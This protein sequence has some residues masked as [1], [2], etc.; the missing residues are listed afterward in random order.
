M[1]AL[2]LE[3]VEPL[4]RIIAR[5]WADAVTGVQIDS[6]RIREGDLFVAVGGGSDFVEHALARGASAALVPEDA[7]AALAELAAAVRS[8]SKARI[9]GITGSTGKTSTKDILF[10][11]CA[12]HAAHDRERG[13]LQQRARSPVDAL[14][15]RA[16]DRDLHQRDGDARTRADR[17][18]GRDGPARHRRD[19]EH[20]PCAPRA[21]RDGR[22]RRTREGRADRRPACRRHRRRPATSRCSSR[23]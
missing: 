14:P 6:R 18:A 4:G 21:R 22:E 7:H 5:P 20:R 13:Q 9:V 11:L 3:V 12:P 1:I 17:A 15:A 23:T 10:A 2:E 8:R 19:H 16:G